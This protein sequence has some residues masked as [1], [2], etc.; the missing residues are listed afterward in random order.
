M[1]RRVI[2]AGTL[3]KDVRTEIYDK[4]TFGR[5][6]GTYPLLVGIPMK[7]DLDRSFDILVTE[8]GHRS[9]TGIPIPIDINRLPF[10]L[11]KSLPGIDNKQVEEIMKGRPFSGKEDFIKRTTIR[12]LILDY[13]Q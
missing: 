4:I 7:L 9:I 13:I 8:H 2:P 5:Q 12:G 6:L 11:L 3:L 1:L 10:K